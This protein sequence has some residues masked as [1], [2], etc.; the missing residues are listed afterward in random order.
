MPQPRAIVKDQGG[1]RPGLNSSGQ[2]IAKHR[3]V[4]KDTDV[5]DG[6]VL[7]TAGTTLPFAVTMA[8]IT[9]GYAG[10]CQVEG[11]AITEAGAELAIGA[12]V[13]GGTGGKAVVATAGQYYLG[14]VAS[15]AAADG[16]LFEL[17]IEPGTVPA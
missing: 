6:I 13:T 14:E 17:D 1:I 15:Y 9:D 11:R 8:A 10:D 2:T 12:K 16:S 7:N 5:V 4:R 3:I